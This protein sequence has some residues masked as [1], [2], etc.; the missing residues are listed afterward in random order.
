MTHEEALQE[1]LFGIDNR[2]SATPQIGTD[3]GVSN[4]RSFTPLNGKTSLQ[5]ISYKAGPCRLVATTSAVI[6]L[7]SAGSWNNCMLRVVPIPGFSGRSSSTSPVEIL[8][9]RAR[10]ERGAA[11]S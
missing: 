2:V 7:E 5:Q 9:T 11:G 3:E 6:G 8:A 4:L 1:S 10:R